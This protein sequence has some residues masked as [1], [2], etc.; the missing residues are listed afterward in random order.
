MKIYCIS[1]LVCLNLACY[2]IVDTGT[3]P[4][5]DSYTTAKGDALKHIIEAPV[6]IPS[7]TE[8][9]TESDIIVQQEITEIDI[10]SE[11]ILALTPDYPGAPYSM[12]LF[13]VI[14]DMTFYDPWRDRW[15]SISEYFQHK[16]HK[17]F[18][19]I[20]QETLRSIQRLVI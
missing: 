6:D 17:A 14:P 15:F 7:N 16:E 19:L 20:P 4:A 9:I 18:I 12:E 10:K 1:L 11:E 2:E 13:K 5:E 8:D 3:I